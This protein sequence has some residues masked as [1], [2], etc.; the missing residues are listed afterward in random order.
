MPAEIV[1]YAEGFENARQRLNNMTNK[2]LIAGSKFFVRKRMEESMDDFVAEVPIGATQELRD[3]MELRI[4]SHGDAITATII[5]MA[6]HAKWVSEGT[7]V[8]GPSKQPIRPVRAKFL[9]FFKEGKWFR[10]R[11]V[12]GQPA[13][14]FLRR[15]ATKLRSTLMSTLPVDARRAVRIVVAGGG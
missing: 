11:S 12:R 14:P 13:N 5:A 3:S 9:S 10:A 6:H 15:G 7:G 1:I 2:K 8:F 4:D